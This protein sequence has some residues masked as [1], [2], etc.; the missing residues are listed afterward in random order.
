MRVVIA[1]VDQNLFEGEAHSLTVPGAAGEMTILGEH[2]PLISTL[3]KGEITVRKTVDDKGQTFPV[4]GGVIE[5][6]HDGATV[7][8]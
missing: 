8:L 6:R 3:K 4:E 7:I 2:M 5:V 1:K